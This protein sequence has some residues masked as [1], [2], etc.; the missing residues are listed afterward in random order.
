MTPDS[1]HSTTVSSIDANDCS[2]LPA[3]VERVIG[4]GNRV[5]RHRRGHRGQRRRQLR[6]R[7]KRVPFPLD[8][9]HR[10]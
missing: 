10:G 3:Y 5:E 4:A 8:D 9:E 2:D 6:G 1:I 7:A